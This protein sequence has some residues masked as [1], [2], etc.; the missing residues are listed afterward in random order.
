MQF[1]HEIKFGGSYVAVTEP[2]NF[3]TATAS[4]T[5]TKNQ[6]L[7]NFA[8]MQLVFKGDAARQINDIYE[9]G[10]KGGKG[11]SSALPYRIRMPNSSLSFDMMLI[12]GHS[13]TRFSCDMVEIPAW[14]VYGQDWLEKNLQAY[15]FW[16]LKKD[17]LITTADEKKTPYLITEIPNYGQVVSLTISEL[18][19]LIYFKDSVRLVVEK[20]KEVAADLTESAIPIVG[21]PHVVVTVIHCLELGLR[22]LLMAFQFAL[23]VK[24]GEQISKNIIQRKKYK[25]CM[26]E[27]DLFK[28]IAQKLGVSI[29]N[30][31][32]VGNLKDATWMPAKSVMPKTLQPSFLDTFIDSLF[33]RPENEENNPKSYGYFDGLFSEF[34]LEMETKYNA[35]LVMDGPTMYFR[36]KNILLKPSNYQLPNTAA[37]SFTS[38]LPNP[39]GTNLSELNPYYGFSFAI[40]K[41]ELNTIHKYR[42]TSAAIQIISPF[43]IDR[44]SGW[45]TGIEIRMNHSLAKRHDYLTKTEETFKRIV[46]FINQA[47]TL[48][49]SPINTVIDAVNLV[50]KGINAIIWVWNKIAPSAWKLNPIPLIPHISLQIPNMFSQRIGWMELSDD[51]FSNPKS[52]I[53]VQI[54]ADWEI[55][56]QSESVMSAYNLLTTKHGSN[57]A[58]RGNQWVNYESNRVKF[59]LPDYDKIKGKN[60]FLAPGGGLGKFD[61]LEWNVAQDVTQVLKWRKNEVYLSG[62]SEKLTIDGI[63]Q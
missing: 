14:P 51:T 3:E 44:Y 46:D 48:I 22:L 11:V 50:I 19:M 55:H 45:G 4:I 16:L 62:L 57:L 39:H 54:G 31:I 25:L 13:S 20:G 6:A 1:I 36:Q 12:M 2:E 61:L 5:F 32:H 59:C 60:L 47:L 56:P 28:K 42:G 63:P 37:I 52:F 26:R 29:V 43:P 8:N 23:I 7:A 24:T 38:H 27:E 18:F 40:D 34:V 10:K 33:D 15:P 17:G 58:T 21:T 53:G 35:E 49:L 9:L 30:T 41:S